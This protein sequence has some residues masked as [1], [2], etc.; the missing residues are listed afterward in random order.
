MF[1][2][3][4]F[5]QYYPVK[6]FVHS[7][8]PR[9]KLVLSIVYM[10]GVFLATS[11]F[12]FAFVALLLLLMVIASKIPLNMVLKT[13]KP[14]LIL[15]VFTAVLNLFFVTDGKVLW[16]W[17]IIT[18]TEGG[19]IF[20]GRMVLRL[21][22]L[23]MGAS[24]LTLTTTPVD[25]THG[26]EVLMYPLT[27]IKFPVHELALIMSIALK[28]IPNLM[29]E[30]DRIIRA[31]KARGADFDTGNIFRRAKAFIPI[32]IPLL[33]SSF[34]RADELALAMDSR[35]Y[36]YTTKRTKMKLLKFT[37]R[38]LIGTIIV[39]IIIAAMITLNSMKGTLGGIYPWMYI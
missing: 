31:Q 36:G 7:M 39:V 16:H 32:L 34:R 20:S 17:W 21:L 2:D 6:S 10:V 18:I 14:V 25:L 35:C 1:R 19:L 27:F 30:T 37:Y 5:G 12:G 13:V 22:F 15:V 29:D 23:V 26:L 38:D 33:I 9:A 3:I 4:T 28:F 24:I 8:D 11:F